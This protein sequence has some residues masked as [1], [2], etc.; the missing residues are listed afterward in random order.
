[1]RVLHLAA[2]IYPLVKT[3]GLADVIAALPPALAARDLDVRVLLPGHP[4]ILDGLRD[5][6]TVI[7]L[8]PAFG[9]AVIKLVG[10]RLEPSG[11][12]AYVIDAPFLYRR[13][14][15]PYVD[16]LGIDWTDNHR[17]FALLGWIA[18]HLA[19]GEL[20]AE[21]IPQI[22]HGHDWHAG[23]APAYIAQNPAMT[24]AT[25]FTIHNLA[26]RGIF[27]IDAAGE[28]G[29]AARKLTPMGLEFHGQIS[30]MKAGLVYSRR[31]TTVS[32][33]YAREICTP[34]YG[35]GLDGVLRDRGPALSGILN[36]VDYTVWSP[37]TDTAI[38][39]RYS[40]RN[41]GG[42]ALCKADVQTAF[43][44]PVEAGVPLFTVVSRLSAQKGLDLLEAILPELSGA[45][46]QLVVLGS[47]DGA[48]E[49]QWRRAAATHP[50]AVAVH[51]GYDESISHRLIAGADALI[52]PSRFE[53]CGL[54]QLYALR[55][56]TVPVVRRVGGLADTVVDASPANLAAGTATGF[57]FGE[58][59]GDALASRLHDACALF[60]DKAAWK[61]LQK[62]GMGQDFSWNESAAHYETLYVDM[63][64]ATTGH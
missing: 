41:L 63:L 64:G 48:I 55:Y 3:G 8:G 40:A 52:V 45:G 15:N 25:V 19:S 29:L 23:L 49:M 43:G 6:R 13:E 18:A 34:E 56:G 2:E 1:M 35:E 24:T 61:R 5:A 42:K 36:G 16:P 9:A 7:T 28:L 27:G 14:G 17:R 57:V 10:G 4:A 31:L 33:T 44:L 21:W 26:Y 53:P 38:K 51:V 58:S 32:P 30:F 60:R 54:T 39:A 37:E 59:N 11:I 47:G 46:A 12:S 50:H 20:D 62:T 22:V